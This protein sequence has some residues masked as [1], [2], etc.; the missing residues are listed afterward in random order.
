M[1]RGAGNMA[2]VSYRPRT[3]VM[4]GLSNFNLAATYPISVFA[5]SSRCQ[6]PFLMHQLSGA[7]NHLAPVYWCSNLQTLKKNPRN[8]ILGA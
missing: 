6:Q 3:V 2:N 7:A 8:L 1:R 4:D 5:L